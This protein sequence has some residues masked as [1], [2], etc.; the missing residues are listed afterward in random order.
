MHSVLYQQP[1]CTEF[2]QGLVSRCWVLVAAAERN[3]DR[4]IVND[5]RAPQVIGN[6]MIGAL[7]VS[8][9]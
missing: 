4:A 1:R 8:L 5:I 3:V 7:I 6:H 2:A 9:G